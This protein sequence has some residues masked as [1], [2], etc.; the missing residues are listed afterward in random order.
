MGWWEDLGNWAG[1]VT[2][3]NAAGRQRDSDDKERRA[4]EEREKRITNLTRGFTGDASQ[5]GAQAMQFAQQQAGEQ[6]NMQ[7]TEAARQ[8]AKGARTAGLNPGQAAVLG[9][10]QTGS[11]WLNAQQAALNQGLQLYNSQQSANLA[12]AGMN[13]FQGPQYTNQGAGQQGMG[14]ANAAA[15]ALGGIAGTG[16]NVVSGSGGNAAPIGG[17]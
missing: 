6:A 5:M 10:Q 16:S 8:A 17:L 1:E 12:A 7:A 4:A 13:P 15:G 9:G 3:W 2:G 11:A 14:F